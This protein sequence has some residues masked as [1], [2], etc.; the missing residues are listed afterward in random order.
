MVVAP[1]VCHDA[2]AVRS[3]D[4]F[5][6]VEADVAAHLVVAKRGVA[7]LI[8]QETVAA[9]EYAELRLVVFISL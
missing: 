3:G 6:A 8:G 2:V 9:A 4:D 1:L 5:A 7:P